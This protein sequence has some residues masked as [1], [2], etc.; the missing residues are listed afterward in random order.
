MFTSRLI[1]FMLVVSPLAFAQT[2][3]AQIP[4]A[5]I[6]DGKYLR[7]MQTAFVDDK[8]QDHVTGVVSNNSP[9]EVSSIQIFVALF[10]KE[11]QFLKMNIGPSLVQTLAAGEKSQFSI[12]VYG[13]E[14]GDSIGSYVVFAHGDVAG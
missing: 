2:I 12:P 8:Y 4:D 7:S 14:D 10:D 1:I 6:I 5:N 3:F 13:V 11:N 9:R